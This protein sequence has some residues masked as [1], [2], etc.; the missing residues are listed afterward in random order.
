MQHRSTSYVIGAGHRAFRVTIV[1]Y[2]NPTSSARATYDQV[3]H[4]G[5]KL[6]KF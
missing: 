4:L 5:G 2:R 1:D 3:V 6:P